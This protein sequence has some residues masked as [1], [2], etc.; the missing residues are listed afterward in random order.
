MGNEET[1]FNTSH[2]TVYHKDAKMKELEK[3][4]FNT[5]HVTVYRKRGKHI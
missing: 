1:D 3:Y 4:N 2:V 5:S